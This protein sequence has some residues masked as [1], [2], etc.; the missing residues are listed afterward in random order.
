MTGIRSFW[1][2]AKALGLKTCGIIKLG[3]YYPIETSGYDPVLMANYCAWLAGLTPQVLDAFEIV[4]EPNNIT[5]FKGLSGQQALV[6][7]TNNCRAA[8]H[9][10][11]P[12]IP[13]IGIGAQ[14][15]DILGMLGLNPGPM[16]D[17]IVYH[18]Y[19]PND[20]IAEH[21]YEPPFTNYLAWVS[22]VRNATSVPIWETERNFSGGSE[23]EGAIWNARRLIISLGIGIEHSFMYDF[24]DSSS[25][26]F[27]TQNFDP[28]AMYITLQRIVKYVCP[29]STLG[30]FQSI[31]PGSTDFDVADSYNYL[32]ASA[33][34]TVAAV[35]LGNFSPS[36]P[37]KHG[38]ATIAF[39][40]ANSVTSKAKIVDTVTGSELPLT[41]WRTSNVGGMLSV[42]NV[43]VTDRPI[44][45]IAQ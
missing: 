38:T 5:Y 26:G 15:N 22:A 30:A 34:S 4:N 24:M 12:S 45:I 28:R 37:P 25:Q 44:L 2:A 21:V 19:D 8:V 13:V 35:W 43:I 10:V 33:T 16:I 9:S 18:P 6:T 41:S 42:F 27:L 14:G 20:N 23:Y 1:A 29:C 11:N 39:P 36:I 3:K 32:F 40:V 17:G 7:L 31:I